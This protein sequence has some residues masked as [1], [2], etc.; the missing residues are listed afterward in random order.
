[1]GVVRY[2][3]ECPG[4]SAPVLL[5]LGVGHDSRQPFFYVC[6]RCK[7][8]TKGA[9][10]WD[11]GAGTILELAAGRLLDC[12]ADYV[13]AVSINP[14]I[15]AF[16][17]AK[18]MAE[19]GGSAFLTFVQWLGGEQIQRYQA[20]DA[21]ARGWLQSDW[22]A[23]ERV[24][25]YYINRDWEHFDPAIAKLLPT[26]AAKELSIGWKRDHYVY[27]LYDVALAPIW[28]L[29][30]SKHFLELKTSWNRLWEPKRKNFTAVVAF[31]KEEANTSD[32]LNVQSDLF[33]CISRYVALFPAI[34]PGLLCN[35]LPDKHQAEVDGLRLFRDEF[36]VLR[37]LYIQTFEAAHKALRWV[38]GASN[39]SKR[40][41]HNRFIA[42][43]G[44]PERIG[45]NPPKS[46]D[47]FS[48]LFSGTKRAWLPLV[49]EWDRRWD[50]LLDR[51]LRND[52]GHGT[53]RHDLA[54]GLINRKAGPPLAYTRFV[55]SCQ[56]LLQPLLACAGAL[57][58]V[59]VYSAA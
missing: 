51:D 46:L 45:K 37:D 41:D 20:A 22:P 8:A 57:K 31:A 33:R 38:I 24:T 56:R 25:T 40:G 18:S 59:Q 3:V 47:G 12:E 11:G 58:I 6:P 1:M 16:A 53:A 9:L 27:R 39:A 50:A 49:P 54:S 19:P 32:F 26:S 5:R 43:P 55:Q 17:G 48:L 52:L 29:D 35:M 42:V 30:P 34:L 13:G 2:P 36:E 10:L 4:C 7:A 21:H 28:T 15:P 44:I 23:L 14:E